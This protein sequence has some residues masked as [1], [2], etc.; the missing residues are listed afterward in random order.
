AAEEA[1]QKARDE[2][3]D[4]AAVIKQA[5]QAVQRLQEVCA[6][7]YGDLPDAYRVLVSPAAVARWEKTAYPGAEDLAAVGGGAAGLGGGRQ[8]GWRRG[9]RRRGGP[10]SSFR[11]GTG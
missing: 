1:Y 7:L 10:N 9:A 6:E 11:T 8:G 3:R 2:Y 4:S 5:G